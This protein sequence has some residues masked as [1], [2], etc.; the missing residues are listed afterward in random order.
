ML[1]EDEDAAKVLRR[2]PAVVQI[3]RPLVLSRVLTVGCFSFTY[4]KGF[5][6]S[7]RSMVYRAAEDDFV[8]TVPGS[9]IEFFNFVDGRFF[10][11]HSV[12]SSAIFIER[13][14]KVRTGA[15]IGQIDVHA[16]RLF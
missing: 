4:E 9:S 10:F 11:S 6:S 7:R 8:D 16:P 12:S 13:R 3:D 15:A 5:K 1:M 14:Q 2:R